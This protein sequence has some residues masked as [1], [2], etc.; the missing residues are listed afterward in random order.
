MA[1]SI[2]ADGGWMF[3]KKDYDKWIKFGELVKERYPVI[4]EIIDSETTETEVP[5]ISKFAGMPLKG[6]CDIID[7][8]NKIVY[9]LKFVSDMSSFKEKVDEWNYN[10]QAALY[11]KG[12]ND[13][14]KFIFIVVEKPSRHN[15]NKPGGNVGIY[16][17]SKDTFELGLLKLHKC[18]N[19]WKHYHIKADN[20]IYY[21]RV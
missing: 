6:K 11:A 14:Y 13:D 12:L 19:I 7:H 9:D 3:L 17:I 8:T 5:L 10:V 16:E 18:I 4:M 1:N 20:K 15:D 2:F 21:H